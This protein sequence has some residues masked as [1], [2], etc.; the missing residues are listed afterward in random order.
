MRDFREALKAEDVKTGI[1]II[2][3][4]SEEQ[5]AAYRFVGSPTFRIDGQDIDPEGERGL[6]Y[7]LT[8]R[9]YHAGSG[10]VSPLPTVAQMRQSVRAARD[11]QARD[12]KPDK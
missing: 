2:E 7:R 12:G 6:P 11:K 10:R 1:E 5:A 9:V 8:C 4:N 3:I